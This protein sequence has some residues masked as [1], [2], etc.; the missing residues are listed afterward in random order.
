MK[1]A[2]CRGCGHFVRI[3]DV[4]EMLCMNCYVKIHNKP[5]KLGGGLSGTKT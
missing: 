1:K 5:K 2:V 3:C 4:A